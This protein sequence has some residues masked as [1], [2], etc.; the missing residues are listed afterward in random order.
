MINTERT[1]KGI[2][3][4]RLGGEPSGYHTGG[5][6]NTE[7]PLKGIQPFRLGGG[8]PSRHHAGGM[9]N[10]EK[11]VKGIQPPPCLPQYH[12]L[13]STSLF[14]LPPLPSTMP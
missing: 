8:E 3:P 5:M 1:P 10:T 13:K 6:T 7:K 9:I 12:H 4:F 2:Q 14:Q 11:P